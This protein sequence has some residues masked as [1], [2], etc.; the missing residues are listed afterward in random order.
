MNVGTVVREASAQG[1]KIFHLNSHRRPNGNWPSKWSVFAPRKSGIRPESEAL[2][3]VFKV[4]KRRW[5]D[6]NVYVFEHRRGVGQSVLQ[7]DCK[8]GFPSDS[9]NFTRPKRS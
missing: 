7:T 5:I 1:R 4:F 2:Y 3:E 6:E 8:S 9:S